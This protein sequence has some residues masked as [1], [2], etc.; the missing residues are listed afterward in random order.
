MNWMSTLGPES[1]D[2]TKDGNPMIA[3]RTSLLKFTKT[4]ASGYVK[5]YT[6][7]SYKMKLVSHL[8]RAKTKSTEPILQ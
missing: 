2:F 4:A 5:N 6:T 8:H 7:L 3:S 1:S